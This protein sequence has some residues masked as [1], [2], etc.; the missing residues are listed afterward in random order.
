MRTIIGFR[1]EVLIRELATFAQLYFRIAIDQLL[2]YAYHSPTPFLMSIN[3]ISTGLCIFIVCLVCQEVK[4]ITCPFSLQVFI[5][6]EVHVR[7]L[8]DM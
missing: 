8:T 4:Q 1:G 6:R 3:C 7:T 5:L 2:F